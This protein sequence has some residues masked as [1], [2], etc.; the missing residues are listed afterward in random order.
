LRHFI[1]FAKSWIENALNRRR[2][3]DG[4]RRQKGFSQQRLRTT[5]TIENEREPAIACN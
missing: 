1:G 3:S 4:E 2:G 5:G